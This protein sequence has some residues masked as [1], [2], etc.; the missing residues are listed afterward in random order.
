MRNPGGAVQAE[1]RRSIGLLAAAIR[2]SSSTIAYFQ[3]VR[4]R[5]ERVHAEKNQRR[6]AAAGYSIDAARN[7]WTHP[8]LRRLLDVDI[9]HLMT[10]DQLT[11][12]MADGE[13]Y[14]GRSNQRWR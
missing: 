1:A 8:T 14:G 11:C 9:A 10:A 2:E 3:A 13:A 4:A 12:W 7:V 6:L 5:L